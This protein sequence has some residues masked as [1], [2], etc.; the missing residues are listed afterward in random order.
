MFNKRKKSML[1]T[2]IGHTYFYKQSSQP[3]ICRSNFLIYL[4]QCTLCKMQYIGRR[5]TAFNIRLNNHH[6]DAQNPKEDTI[7][8]CTHF[9]RNNHDLNKNARFTIIELIIQD[10]Q[11]QKCQNILWINELLL[12]VKCIDW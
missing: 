5:K 11:V 1:Q 3:T 4:L 12:L 10:N 6:T 8:A 7:P 2:G 9:H